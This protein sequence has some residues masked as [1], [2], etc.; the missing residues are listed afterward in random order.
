MVLSCEELVKESPN[1][2][3]WV[4]GAAIRSEPTMYAHKENVNPRAGKDCAGDL[5][6]QAGITNP[7]KE[8]DMAEIYVPFSWFEPMWMENLGFCDEH[9]GWKM[10]VE[11]ATA[12]D[13]DM[14]INCSGA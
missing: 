11:G 5:Y 9:M 2:P 6:K 13:G 14:P 3:A 7:R 4:L 12:I 8:L 1:T 10:T